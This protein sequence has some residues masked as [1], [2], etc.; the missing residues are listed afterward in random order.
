MDIEYE[1][2]TTKRY[3]SD[4]EDFLF[5]EGHLLIYTNKRFVIPIKG[6]FTL[7]VSRVESEKGEW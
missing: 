3:I 6:D 4:V 1:D 2:S 5:Q 7:K